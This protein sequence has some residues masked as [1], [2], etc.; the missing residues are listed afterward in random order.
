MQT[1]PTMLLS[2]SLNFSLHSETIVSLQFLAYRL[3][4]GYLDG[5]LDCHQCLIYRLTQCTALSLLSI[6]Y[7]RMLYLLIT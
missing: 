6:A 5:G 1:I 3:T 2:S 7:M 4:Q